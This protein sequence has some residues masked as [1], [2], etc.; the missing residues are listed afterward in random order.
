MKTRAHKVLFEKDSPYGHR[1]EQTKK[2]KLDSK[3]LTMNEILDEEYYYEP[4][5]DEPFDPSE[6]N[7]P[8]WR[9][10]MNDCR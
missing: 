8:L 4:E 3:K 9:K 2:E 5:D 10:K 6:L 1:I 7:L